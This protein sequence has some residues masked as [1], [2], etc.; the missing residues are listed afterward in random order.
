M[1]V[2]MEAEVMATVAEMGQIGNISFLL[3]FRPF[4]FFGLNYMDS[5][6]D[7]F[8]QCGH[9]RSTSNEG[10]RL[11]PGEKSNWMLKLQRCVKVYG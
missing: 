9:N 3:D 4:G 11:C 7:V 5:F 8:R 10:A 1:V 6:L 2:T